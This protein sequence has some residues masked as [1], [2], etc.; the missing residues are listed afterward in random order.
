ML[1]AIP[2]AVLGLILVRTAFAP[3]PDPR[4]VLADILGG[5]G[6]GIGKGGGGGESVEDMLNRV[7]PKVSSGLDT[8][9][10]IPQPTSRPGS[11][12]ITIPTLRVE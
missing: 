1:V 12:N 5:R 11:L 6:L 3:E 7:A 2:L 8:R 9:P 10:P 4:K